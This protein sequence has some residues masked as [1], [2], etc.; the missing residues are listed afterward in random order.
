MQKLNK[1]SEKIWRE[2]V[3]ESKKWDGG[4][5]AKSKSF[6]PLCVEQIGSLFIAETPCTLWSFAH[7]GQQNGDAMRDPDVEFIDGGDVWGIIPISFR[8]DYLAALDEGARIEDGRLIGIY[9]KK[10]ASICSFCNQWMTNIK[11]QQNI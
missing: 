4:K 8:N 3:E 1:T 11:E 6:M 2:I 9:L 5:I 10:Q 7:Y